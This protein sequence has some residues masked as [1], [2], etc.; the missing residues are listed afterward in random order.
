[1]CK[2]CQQRFER[3]GSLPW[4]EKAM[5][6]VDMPLSATSPLPGDQ[7]KSS[8]YT[9]PEGVYV[10]MIARAITFDFAN[11]KIRLTGDAGQLSRA[12]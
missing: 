4:I 3:E 11:N 1:M 2:A 5:E 8:D 7:V 6:I 10:D 9:F 12:I